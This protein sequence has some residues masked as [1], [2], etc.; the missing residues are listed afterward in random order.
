VPLGA[1]IF[2]RGFVDETE[3]DHEDVGIVITD[4][5]DTSK[6]VLARCVEDFQLDVVT[7][8]L[9][10]ALVRIN[11]GRRQSLRKLVLTISY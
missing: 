2:K 8:V 6:V 1:R 5:S 9:R 10:L 4:R 3:A 7:F 11:D